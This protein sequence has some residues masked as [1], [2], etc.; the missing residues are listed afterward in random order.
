M[1]YVHAYQSYVWNRAVSARIELFGCRDVVEGDLILE[2]DGEPAEEDA[3]AE[4]ASAPRG[5]AKEDFSLEPDLDGGKSCKSSI[6]LATWLITI[7]LSTDDEVSLSA[8]VADPA[9]RTEV[10][11]AIA[12]SKVAKVHVVTAEDVAAK[13][14]SIFDVVL[15]LPG[16]AI[17]YPTGKVGACYKDI[18]RAD[19]LDPDDMYRKQKEYSLGGAYRKILHH[20]SHVEARQLLYTSSQADL[21]Q[22]DEDALLGRPKPDAQEY[23]GVG[24]VPEGASVALQIE[25]TLGSSTYATMAMREVL[26]TRTSSADQTERTKEMEEREREFQRKVEEG[27][28]AGVVGVGAREV[29]EGKVSAEAVEALPEEVVMEVD[30]LKQAEAE[31]AAN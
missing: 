13:R 30:A 24:P 27:K 16:F 15:P 23:D 18:M 22:S 26:K 6:P 20:P 3:G 29:L 10:A 12:S 17:T 5:R 14:F 25:L 11:A 7:D 21:A 28:E 2:G 19:R 4:S 8:P 9:A 31:V 1:M